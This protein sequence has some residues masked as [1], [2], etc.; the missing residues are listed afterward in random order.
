MRE[1]EKGRERWECVLYCKG[2]QLKSSECMEAATPASCVCW[3]LC[4]VELYGDVCVGFLEG[5][6]IH[7]IL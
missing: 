4:G 6:Y 3:I 1:G 5:L 7:L 2:A